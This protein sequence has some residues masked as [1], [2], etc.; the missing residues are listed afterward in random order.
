MVT[1]NRSEEGRGSW[2]ALCPHTTHTDT[3]TER[4]WLAM[5]SFTAG[6]FNRLQ[7]VGHIHTCLSS[8]GPHGYE[9]EY[10]YWN[11]M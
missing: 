7:T 6:G 11:F 1:H 9:N 5:N 10:I 2:V 8:H 3:D 4:L